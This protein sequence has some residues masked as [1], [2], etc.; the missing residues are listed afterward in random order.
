MLVP[1]RRLSL[2]LLP[3]LLLVLLR[4]RTVDIQYRR[5]LT[6]RPA[7]TVSLITAR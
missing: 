5:R 7:M 3:P 6:Q 2:L 1:S 4:R